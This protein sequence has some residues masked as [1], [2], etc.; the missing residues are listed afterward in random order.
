MPGPDRAVA[1]VRRAVRSAIADV[2]AGELVLAACS[3]GADSVA[4]AAGLAWEAPR[5]GVRAG[6][7][8]VDHRL[9]AGSALVADSV[10]RLAKSLG[11]DTVECVQV[12]AV[13]AKGG[14][15]PEAAAR[16]ARYAAI[17]AVAGRLGAV[18]VLLGHT[19]DD[20]AETV[21][22]GLGRGSGARSLAGMPGARDALRRPLLGLRRADTVACCAA[23]GLDVWTDPANADPRFARNRVR[24]TVLPTLERELGP[25]VAE[26][27][28]R[29]A[30]QLRADADLLDEL[31]DAAYADATCASAAGG[32]G[33]SGRGARVALDV[34]VLAALPEALRG[35][36]LHRAARAAGV[37][38][39]ALSAVH[40]GAMAELVTG[41]KGQGPVDLP[42]GLAATRRCATLHLEPRAGPLE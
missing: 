22:L 36:V 12:S 6:V 2:P 15:G 16:D 4:L 8:H 24:A 38:G 25:G 40:V 5:A 41:W 23:L 17:D 19:L 9:A 13:A 7:V 42:G 26:A 20:Q 32:V 3:G 1:A 18:A 34:A 29:T 30:H 21:L 11:I 28:A 37:P 39:S 14:P 31:A 10:A 27:L 35:R 33:D